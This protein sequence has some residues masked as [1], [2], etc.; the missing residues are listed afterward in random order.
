ML[1]RFFRSGFF[2]HHLVIIATALLLWLP[3]LIRPSPPIELNCWQPIYDWLKTLLLPYPLISTVLAFLLMLISALYLNK[4]LAENG[5]I[6]RSAT[7]A[8]FVFV[9]LTS[10]E[11]QQTMFSPIWIAL[12]LLIYLVSL[13]FGMY[14]TNDNESAIFKA[15]MVVAVLSMI[16]FPLI[17]L[18]LWVYVALLIM[19]ISKTN[20]WI[21][22]LTGL[23]LPYFLLASYFF[24]K[25]KLLFETQLFTTFIDGLTLGF[26][27]S[28]K[29]LPLLI[30]LLLVVLLIHS[31]V[32][33][34][35][36]V[37]DH[38]IFM[39]KKKA[40]LN[41]LIFFSIPML[42][43]EENMW[44][45]FQIIFIPIT[46][47]IGFSWM[48]YKRFFWPQLLIILLFGIAVINQYSYLF[49]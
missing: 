21:I 33:V 2:I 47:Y 46:S 30:S 35:S 7:A 38:G 49:Q 29:L 13:F 18:W 37:S 26:A 22:P 5:I 45:D 44:L 4:V 36:P 11:Q 3:A 6:G 24:L 17:V 31:M 27:V 15:T 42:F 41:A 39:R 8:A 19:R 12:P 23:L 1:I 20:E 9:I 14:E 48:L 28:P 25:N 43:F 34:A 10:W 32:I 16:S 40:I